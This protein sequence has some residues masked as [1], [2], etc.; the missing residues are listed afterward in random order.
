MNAPLVL[1]Y[2][3]DNRNGSR[4]RLICLKLHIRVRTVAPTE[5][6]EPVGALAGLMELTGAPAEG[7]PFA[8]EM[9]VMVHFGGKLLNQF[10]QEI[11]AAHLPGVW[12]GACPRRERED[13]LLPAGVRNLRRQALSYD[14]RDGRA[15]SHPRAR[16]VHL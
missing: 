6:A 11:R 13:P 5:L 14:E 16:S 1:L 3:L 8:D 2:N 9:M 10:L 7:E 15:R 4:L 12:R